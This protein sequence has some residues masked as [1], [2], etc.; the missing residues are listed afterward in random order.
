MMAIKKCE[1]GQVIG[2][3]NYLGVCRICRR[4]YSRIKARAD[5]KIRRASRRKVKK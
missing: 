3:H 4:K 5:Y 1:C 2:R